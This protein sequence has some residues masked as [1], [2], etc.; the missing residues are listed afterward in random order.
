MTT[1]EL[2]ALDRG[3]QDRCQCLLVSCPSPIQWTI[4]AEKILAD[5]GVSTTPHA[6]HSLLA[7][8]ESFRDF[9]RA[10]DGLVV[11]SR[12]NQS[13]PPPKPPSLTVILG[14]GPTP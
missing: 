6:L 12:T 1:N 11:A 2:A 13:P 4:R 10:L 3:L 14:S 9:L 5:E 7:T 8:A